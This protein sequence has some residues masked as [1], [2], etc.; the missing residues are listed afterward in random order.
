MIK[1]DYGSYTSPNGRRA[2]TKEGALE[3][4][5]NQIALVP[6]SSETHAAEDVAIYAK[7][8]WAHLF[9]GTVEQNYI[10]HVMKQAFQF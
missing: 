9:Q 6:R 4:D 3:S 10:F 2:S 7:G 8:P 5:Y 1:D